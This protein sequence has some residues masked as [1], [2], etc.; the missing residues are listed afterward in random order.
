MEWLFIGSVGPKV[1]EV[2]KILAANGYWPAGYK[3]TD[4]YTKR[5]AGKVA[6]FQGQHLNK[7]GE[8]CGVDGEVGPETWWALK[9]PTGKAQQS[10]IKAPAPMLTVS[11]GGVVARL[12]LIV[13]APRFRFSSCLRQAMT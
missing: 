2:K 1:V 11:D 6:E 12:R 13:E 4:R 10:G 3:F 7:N 9:H 5:L 8:W